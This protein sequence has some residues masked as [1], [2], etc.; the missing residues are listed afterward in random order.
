LSLE[1][2]IFFPTF[3]DFEPSRARVGSATRK[4]RPS[5]GR[6]SWLAK[7]GGGFRSPAVTVSHPKKSEGIGSINQDFF[8]G[9]TINKKD[10]FGGIFNG[11]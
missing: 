2:A 11:E 3:R 5:Q 4:G 10:F 7:F 6:A 1:V 8:E 9:I